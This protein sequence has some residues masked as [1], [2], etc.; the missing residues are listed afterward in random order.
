M[1]RDGLLE[2]AACKLQ[3]PKNTDAGRFHLFTSGRAE[4]RKLGVL[5]PKSGDGIE[6]VGRKMRREAVG[7]QID[8]VV[9]GDF[10]CVEDPG[11]DAMP[12][13]DDWR[14][15]PDHVIAQAVKRAAYSLSVLILQQEAKSEAMTTATAAVASWAGVQQAP[16]VGKRQFL[17]LLLLNRCTRVAVK[18]EALNRRS[19]VEMR[20]ADNPSKKLFLYSDHLVHDSLLAL[21][22]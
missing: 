11:M 13:A 21:G 20:V 3:A 7:E 22:Q 6:E 15:V 8:L 16:D 1:T 4:W 12:P 17:R 18:L 19:N 9:A 5:L 2:R 14:A 10:N